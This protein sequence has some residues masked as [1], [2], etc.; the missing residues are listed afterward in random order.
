MPWRVVAAKASTPQSRPRATWMFDG[1][2]MSDLGRLEAAG[3]NTP[4]VMSVRP[5][6]LPLGEPPRAARP[7]LRR[8]S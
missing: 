8:P 2:R 3:S 1:S 4:D 7:A 5:C 6:P